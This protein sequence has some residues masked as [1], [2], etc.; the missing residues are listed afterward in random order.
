MT[1]GSVVLT[2]VGGKAAAEGTVEKIVEVR[3][4]LAKGEINVFDTNNFTVNGE[5][6]TSFKADLDGDYVGETEVCY[7]GIIKESFLRSAPYFDLRIDGIKLLN[8]KLG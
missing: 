6:V 5:K 2:N 4:K 1:T 3:T 7:D 8:E